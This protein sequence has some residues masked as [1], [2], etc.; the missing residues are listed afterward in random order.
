MERLVLEPLVKQ[1][2]GLRPMAKLL[3]TSPTNVRYWMRKYGLN[4]KQ[5][6]F[7]QGY[8]ARPTPYKCGRCGETDSE[9]FYGHKRRICGQCHN[10]YNLKQG[11]D[12]RLRA[13][14]E[15]GGR[16]IICGFD[17][18]PCSLDFHHKNRRVKDP[19]YRSMRGWSWKK[20]LIELEKCILLCKNCHAAIHAGFLE[21]DTVN[22]GA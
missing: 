10:A 13:I 11:Q 18:Y 12:K 7:G 19:N 3:G 14:K 21:I 1:G 22:I 16:C 5:R 20:I 4:L 15:L 6:P 9:K 2:I 8:V 17:R